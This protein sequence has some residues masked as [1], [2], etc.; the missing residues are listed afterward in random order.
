MKTTMYVEKRANICIQKERKIL[1]WRPK[2]ISETLASQLAESKQT[3]GAPRYVK[4]YTYHGST[5]MYVLR[6]HIDCLTGYSFSF[7]GNSL[8]TKTQHSV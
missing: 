8:G 3:K 4:I 5:T 6:K 7:T 1:A 2:T